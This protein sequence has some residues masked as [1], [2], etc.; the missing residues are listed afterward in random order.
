VCPI[1]LVAIATL[2]NWL[3]A[4]CVGGVDPQTALRLE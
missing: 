3:P 2:A 1:V 4:C